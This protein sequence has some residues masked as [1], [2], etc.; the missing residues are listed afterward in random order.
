MGDSPE[1]SP[2]IFIRG[3]EPWLMNYCWRTPFKVLGV[4]SLVKVSPAVLPSK[5]T[6]AAHKFG[7]F[8]FANSLRSVSETRSG[9]NSKGYRGEHGTQT[10]P[11][12]A[13]PKRV[14][15]SPSRPAAGGRCRP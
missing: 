11:D 12:P 10:C 5:K 14:G 3:G 1:N 2:A 7:T 9:C 4:P 13:P 8:E 6:W 15:R